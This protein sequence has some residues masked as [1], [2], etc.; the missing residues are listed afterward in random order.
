MLVVL[1]IVVVVVVV[2]VSSKR[3]PSNGGR[4]PTYTVPIP[5]RTVRYGT[6]RSYNPQECKN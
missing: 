5:V 2:V 3:L 6:V 1:L 4:L